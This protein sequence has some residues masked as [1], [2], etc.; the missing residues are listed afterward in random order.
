MNAMIGKTN[1]PQKMSI[2]NADRGRKRKS[3]Q[4]EEIIATSQLNNQ[5][6]SGNH[7]A[8]LSKEGAGKATE[9]SAKRPLPRP[10]R[11]TVPVTKQIP[12]VSI[13]NLSANDHS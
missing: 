6:P 8:N 7:T 9:P 5:Q 13:L 1:I 3:I 11:K 12:S 4:D 2:P 10:V